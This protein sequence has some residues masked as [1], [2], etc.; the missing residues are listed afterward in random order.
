MIRPAGFRPALQSRVGLAQ[1]L[2][3][4]RVASVESQRALQGSQRLLGLAGL[5]Q[6]LA[7][8]KLGA[9]VGWIQPGR[10]SKSGAGILPLAQATVD[11]AQT[12]VRLCQLGV[13]LQGAPVGRQR[14]FPLA[15]LAGNVTQ[16]DVGQR[17]FGRQDD[18]A[19]QTLICFLPAAEPDQR[20][21]ERDVQIGPVGRQR[22]RPPVGSDGALGCAACGGNIA[23]LFVRSRVGG[24]Q[25]HGLAQAAQGGSRLVLGEVHARQPVQGRRVALSPVERCFVSRPGLLP[26]FQPYVSVA[27]AG[28]K[29]GAAFA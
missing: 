12:V 5:Q 7:Q 27:Q 6:Q 11:L 10:R 15:R 25:G 23:N 3:G 17:F 2:V 16:P 24:L 1:R 19:S 29:F 21:A 4:P 20:V 18:G 9:G 14:L 13:E 22:Q 28:V 26:P 8:G